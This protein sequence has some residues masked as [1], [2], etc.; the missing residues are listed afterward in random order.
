MDTNTEIEIEMQTLNKLNWLC[1]NCKYSGKCIT[2]K[3]SVTPVYYC[4]E[5]FV[6]AKKHLPITDKTVKPIPYESENLIGLCG[7][8]SVSENCSLRSEERI[9]FNCEHYH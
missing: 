4:E 6:E 3:M 2:E 7:S 9:I 1:P 5:H 8:C